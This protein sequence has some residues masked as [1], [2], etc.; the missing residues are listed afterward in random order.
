MHEKSLTDVD[1]AKRFN[2]SVR[3]VRGWRMKGVGPAYRKLGGTIRYFEEDVRNY[4]DQSRVE[5]YSRQA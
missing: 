5:P 3:T 4:E 2:V 1:L